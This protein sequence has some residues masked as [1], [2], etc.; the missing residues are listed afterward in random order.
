MTYSALFCSEVNKFYVLLHAKLFS[1]TRTARCCAAMRA[2]HHHAQRGFHRH[3]RF[4]DGAV[5][6]RLF[7]F[8]LIY[9]CNTEIFSLGRFAY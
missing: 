7:L 3:H 1:H 6:G 5:E 8:T 2:A 9:D 4:S